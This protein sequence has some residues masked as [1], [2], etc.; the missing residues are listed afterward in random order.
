MSLDVD[1][2]E[3]G[4]DQEF[5][6][7]EDHHRDIMNYLEL[8]DRAAESELFRHIQ[9]GTTPL[10]G[11]TLDDIRIRRKMIQTQLHLQRR[12]RCIKTCA[13][14]SI[15]FLFFAVVFLSFVHLANARVVVRRVERLVEE[16]DRVGP[17]QHHVASVERSRVRCIDGKVTRE[18][19]VFLVRM[20]V[21]HVER[22]GA[23]T[24]LDRV[25]ALGLKALEL[26]AGVGGGHRGSQP[27]SAGADR[28]CG[29]P[30]FGWSESRCSVVRSTAPSRTRPLCVYSVS[31]E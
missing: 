7:E 10:T 1:H 17:I 12:R 18:V 31:R 19:G 30:G 15:A 9:F 29:Q 8:E 3:Q 22:V 2:V 4:V 26:G 14:H 23:K 16:H 5:Q 11:E 25:E 21:G 6:D 13:A 28:L 27:R 24:G 20:Q